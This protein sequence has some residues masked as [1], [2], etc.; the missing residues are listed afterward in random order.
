MHSYYIVSGII[1]ILSTIDFAAAA[2]V[3]AQEKRQAPAKHIPEDS[4]T[5]LGKRGGDWSTLFTLT[6]DHFPKPEESSAA[7]PLSSSLSSV[8]DD[9]WAVVDKPLLSVP[10]K[11][12]STMS[13]ADYEFVG[14]HALPNA[15]SS[16]ASGHEGLMGAHASQPNLNPSNARPLTESESENRLAVAGAPSRPTPPTE[17]D[18]G[19]E[20]QV[21]RPPQTVPKPSPGSASPTE[22]DPFYWKAYGDIPDRRSMG[23]DS[24]LENL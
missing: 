16:I 13:D 15:K 1:L 21:A 3:L 17:F 22:Y 9:E 23:A 11:S 4:I 24:R 5:M 2:P 19:Q 7:R 12:S 18:A 20:Y 6:E 14:V 8:P 10:E